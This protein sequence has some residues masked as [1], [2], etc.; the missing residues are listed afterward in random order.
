MNTFQI[1]GE[2]ENFWG[3]VET[4]PPTPGVTALEGVHFL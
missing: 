3:G 4:P 2:L 1:F